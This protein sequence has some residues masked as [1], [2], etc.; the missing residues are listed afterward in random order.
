[1]FCVPWVGLQCVIVVFPDQNSL[2]FSLLGT[3]NFF[4]TSVEVHGIRKPVYRALTY[5][6]IQLLTNE[7]LDMM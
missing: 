7:A 2:T 1:M 3:S 5:N 6:I 4:T